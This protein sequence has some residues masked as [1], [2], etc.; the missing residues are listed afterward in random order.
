ML[1]FRLL[2]RQGSVPEVM[3]IGEGASLP[4][5]I[6]AT[7]FSDFKDNNKALSDAQG[8]IRLRQLKLLQELQI[9]LEKQ[10]QVVD[11]VF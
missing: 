3:Q 1:H 4:H 9:V 5:F 6:Y 11:A 7:I 2:L 8:F 10:S